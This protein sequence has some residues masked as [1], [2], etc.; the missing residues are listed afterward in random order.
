[1]AKGQGRT[2][3]RRDGRVGTQRREW[4]GD[5]LEEQTGG[6]RSMM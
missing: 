5:V 2:P 1:V 3:T 6:M 4:S